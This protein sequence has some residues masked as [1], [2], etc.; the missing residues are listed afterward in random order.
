[1]VNNSSS[2]FSQIVSNS[3]VITDRAKQILL[4]NEGSIDKEVKDKITGTI[5]NYETS[6][7]KAVEVYLKNKPEN[8][9]DIYQNT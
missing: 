6:V 4:Q 9:K 2:F 8:H 3:P 7:F 1:M 5:L